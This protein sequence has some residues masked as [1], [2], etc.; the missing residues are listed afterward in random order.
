V[1]FW[2]LGIVC[3]Q[4]DHYQVSFSS[5]LLK[6]HYRKQHAT[7]VLANSSKISMSLI[8]KHFSSFPHSAIISSS[9]RSA[10]TLRHEGLRDL[11]LYMSSL[12]FLHTVNRPCWK[13]T[14]IFQ[15]HVLKKKVSGSRQLHLKYPAGKNKHQEFSLSLR[16]PGVY[17]D[18]PLSCEFLFDG[19]EVMEI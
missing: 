11:G 7:N 14:P 19:N 15:E 18:P 4:F 3:L 1:L 13:Y 9:S 8:L 16:W 2:C 17:E 6:R 10:G 5:A 12:L